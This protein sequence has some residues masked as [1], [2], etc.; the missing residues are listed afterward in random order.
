MNLG[1]IDVPSLTETGP[2]FAAE[3]P[4][5]ASGMSRAGRDSR[6]VG[7][8]LCWVS[9]PLISSFHELGAWSRG[10]GFVT[11]VALTCGSSSVFAQEL[12]PRAYRSLPVGRN[13]GILVYSFSTGDVVIDP[14]IP[15]E[16]LEAEIH[17]RTAGYMRTFPLFGR[18]ST[19]TANLPY[20]VHASGAGTRNAVMV[21]GVRSGPAD[22]R[23]RLTHLLVGAPALTLTW[24][25]SR[26]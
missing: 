2:Q 11:A 24:A 15:V 5:H 16:D 6:S 26:T 21:D 7:V 3:R 19:L 23:F 22:A 13:F 18:S 9:M 12:E 20:V 14:T 25:P 17:S 10:V 4:S 1:D 8:F